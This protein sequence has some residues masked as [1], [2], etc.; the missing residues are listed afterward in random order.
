MD[1]FLRNGDAY[2]TRA[3]GNIQSRL[4][5]ENV[6]RL[7]AST[8]DNNESE[9]SYSYSESGEEDGDEDSDEEKC[10]EKAIVPID[11][12]NSKDK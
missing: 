11:E 3:L 6:Q 9:D 5:P 10:E 1:N 12:E 2:V 4:A 8:D 7:V